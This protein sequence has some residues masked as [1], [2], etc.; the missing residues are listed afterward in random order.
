M[1]LEWSDLAGALA[2]LL[3]IEGLLPFANPA[4]MKR[5]MA[6]VAALGERE[7]RIAGFATMLVGLVL[8]FFVRA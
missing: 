4:G 7:L 8:L 2:L 5:T 3:V 1:S 6:R